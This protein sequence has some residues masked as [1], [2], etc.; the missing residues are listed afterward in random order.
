MIAHMVNTMK[1]LVT[2]AKGMLGTDFC[3]YIKKNNLAPIEW[4]LPDNDITEVNRTIKN[5][6]QLKPQVIV[7]FAAY[8]DVDGCELN[9]SK[10]YAVN[11]Q[12]TWAMVLATKEIGAKFIYISTDYVF[13]G[14]KESYQETDTPNPINYYGLTKFLGE[15]LV[16]Q[17]LK[18]YF[19]VRTSWLFGKHGKNF[20]STILKLAREEKQ[21][22]VVNDQIG[23][24]TYTKDLCEP[25]Y[26]LMNCEHYGIYHLTNSGICSW[27]DFAK[28]II[29]QTGLT[30]PVIPITS[31]KLTRPAK[32]PNFSVL[33]N[34]N[35][36]KI[37]N[38][39]LRNWQEAL[40]DFLKESSTQ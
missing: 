8:T 1:I 21:L 19:I 22:E 35:Y 6:E 31:D 5:I 12:G 13:D 20:V 14:K 36:K 27:Y 3:E 7:H 25:L 10:A 28:E 37:F 24:P 33:E 2:G 32:R 40:N 17:H 30:T 29:K 34:H 9:K 39:S 26:Q 4:D 16:L 11:T 18:K 23:S 15:Q 38:K